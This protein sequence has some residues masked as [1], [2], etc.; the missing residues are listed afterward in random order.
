MRHTRIGLT[1]KVSLTL[2]VVLMLTFAFAATVSAKPAEPEATPDFIPHC[3]YGQ[4][5]TS[6]G[7][8]LPG[9]LVIARPATGAWTGSASTTID[10][11]SRYGYSPSLCVPGN[12][13]G[14][15]GAQPGDQI[16]FYVLGVQALLYD[17]ATGV[18]SMTYVFD[19]DSHPSGSNVNLTVPIKYTITATTGLNGSISPA[20]QVKVEYG[21]DQTFRFTPDPGYIILDVLVDGVSNPAAVAAGSYTFEDVLVNHTIHVTFVQEFYTI[22]PTAGVGCTIEPGTPQ[23]VRYMNSAIFNISAKTGY[24][25]VNVFVDG[26]AQGAIPSYTFSNVMADHTISATCKLKEFIVTPM[27]GAGGTIVPGTPQTVQYGGS[28][29]FQI[30]P[31]VGYVVDNVTVNGAS[32]GALTE[33][34]FTNVI[35]NGTITATFKLQVFTITPTAGAGGTIS[36]NTVQAVNYGGS[37]T[38]TITPDKGYMIQDVKVD[39]TSVGA[40]T[41]YTFSDVKANGTIEV[42]FAK[43]TY[44]LYLPLVTR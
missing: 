38:F 9:E 8:A 43:I 28:I 42:T 27:A 16:A 25:L 18:D 44:M 4:V 37:V 34:T 39:G 36:P 24:D 1:G 31:N 7:L 12:M 6:G 19:P 26:A 41:S 5:K 32:M 20:G 40:V 30:V 11:Q 3:F 23:T 15:S 10:S 21:Y 22:T 17:V 35:E 13:G 14:G 29:T 33:Y 2:I